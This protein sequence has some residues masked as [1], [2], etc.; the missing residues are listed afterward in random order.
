MACPKKFTKA[1]STLL[2]AIVWKT[3][4]VNAKVIM[5]L[6][7]MTKI[8]CLLAVFIVFVDSRELICY[9]APVLDSVALPYRLAAE[10]ILDELVRTVTSRALKRYFPNLTRV[11]KEFLSTILYLY[12]AIAGSVSDNIR[13][14]R[15]VIREAPTTRL[16]DL[17]A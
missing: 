17:V 14:C 6:A 15:S 9:T 3:Y 12:Y 13:I 5:L 8:E 10:H 7:V 16:R 1:V 2:T 4:R 11:L